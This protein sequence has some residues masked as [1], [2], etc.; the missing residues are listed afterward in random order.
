MGD[1]MYSD[2]ESVYSKDEKTDWGPFLMWASA[3]SMARCFKTYQ[4]TLAHSHSVFY[5]VGL[6]QDEI[7]DSGEE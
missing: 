3:E 7:L 2:F 5:R 6:R 1:F 4:E